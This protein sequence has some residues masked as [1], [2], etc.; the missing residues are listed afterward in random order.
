MIKQFSR[1][2]VAALKRTLKNISPLLRRRATLEKQ[3]NAI[4]A[5]LKEVDDKIDAYK[6]MMDPII[7]GIDPEIIIANEG[8]VEIADKPEIPEAEVSM[9]PQ[10]EMERVQEA[11]F[12]G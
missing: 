6:Q 10:P 3:A 9:E 12:L 4:L 1:F 5:E 8:K 11:P 7:G 2:E